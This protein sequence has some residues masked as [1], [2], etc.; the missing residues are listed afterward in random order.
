M[1][2]PDKDR[3]VKGDDDGTSE[4]LSRLGKSERYP[5]GPHVSVSRGMFES[6]FLLT[7]SRRSSLSRVDEIFLVGAIFDRN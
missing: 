2:H 6:A 4:T 7:I 1:P 3:N 5:F